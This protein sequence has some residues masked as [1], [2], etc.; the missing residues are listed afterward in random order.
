[1]VSLP[2]KPKKT[3]LM[4][5]V[6]NIPLRAEWHDLT[7]ANYELIAKSIKFIAPYEGSLL[8]PITKIL[9]PITSFRVKTTYIDNKYDPYSITCAYGSSMIEGV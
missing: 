5:D 1:M 6:V 2:S 9:R 7:L 4:C 3:D 8:P